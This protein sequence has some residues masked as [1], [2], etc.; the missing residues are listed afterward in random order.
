M[1]KTLSRVQRPPSEAMVKV[2]H[3]ITQAL[4]ANKF[5]RHPDVIVNISAV[6]CICEIIRIM[7][8]NAP[9]NHE[10]MKV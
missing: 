3:P 1:E 5:V 9:Y 8:P 10:Q 4:I 2:L 6:C 7:A